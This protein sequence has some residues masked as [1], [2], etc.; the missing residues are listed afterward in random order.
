MSGLTAASGNKDRCA[1]AGLLLSPSHQ[2]FGI[3][4]YSPRSLRCDGI[5]AC[6]KLDVS[7]VGRVYGQ[8]LR[9]QG[10]KGEASQVGDMVIK[11]ED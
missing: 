6:S 1:A 9:A 7:R 3:S 11:V 2:L 8:S 5:E 4:S 10:T